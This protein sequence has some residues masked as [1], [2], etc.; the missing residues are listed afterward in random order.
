MA[1][2]LTVQRIVSQGRRCSWCNGM[3][4][5][6]PPPQDDMELAVNGFNVVPR[7]KMFVEIKLP[8]QFH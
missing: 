1:L 7:K 5:K 2:V 3:E 4:I 8:P 6:L